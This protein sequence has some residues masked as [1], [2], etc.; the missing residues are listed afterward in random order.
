MMRHTPGDRLNLRDSLTEVRQMNDGLTVLIPTVVEKST[1]DRDTD[2]DRDVSLG[3]G[4]GRTATWTVQQIQAMVREVNVHLVT[5]GSV[6]PGAEIGDLLVAIGVRDVATFTAAQ[7]NEFAYV[8][9]R[10]ERYKIWGI[11]GLGVA[12]VEEYIVWLRRSGQT[13]LRNP[14]Y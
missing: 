7:L 6:P 11:N 12:R 4:T 9:A 10:N 5:F 1:F 14:D 8:W 3:D 13:V 2:A